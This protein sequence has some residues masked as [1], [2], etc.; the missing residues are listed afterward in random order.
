MTG[1]KYLPESP[2]L[3]RPVYI[4]IAL[5]F[6]IA[7]GDYASYE[8]FCLQKNTL[9]PAP[10][11]NPAQCIKNRRGFV[12]EVNASELMAVEGLDMCAIA[13]HCGDVT[14]AMQL[15]E[16]GGSRD[17]WSQLSFLSLALF[18][19]QCSCTDSISQIW[20]PSFWW[21]KEIM[22]SYS[23]ANVRCP[24]YGPLFQHCWKAAKL[25]AC[26]NQQRSCPFVIQL[27]G[28]AVSQ[29]WVERADPPPRL[30]AQACH[31]FAL[32]S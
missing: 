25:I 32:W 31:W 27:Q 19:S 23:A 17:V 15:L 26:I 22:W 7:K 1:K 6:V 10:F 21:T 18:G 28:A 24:R 14:W 11:P 29:D 8:K 3:L 9:L 13:G 12:S 16:S 2:L 5:V 4:V 30:P 20:H